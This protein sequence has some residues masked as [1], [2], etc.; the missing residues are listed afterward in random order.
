MSVNID[1]HYQCTFAENAGLLWYGVFRGTRSFVIGGLLWYEVFCDRGRFV[2]GGVLWYGVFCD[3]GFIQFGIRARRN[4]WRNLDKATLSHFP[5][6]IKKEQSL[7][8]YFWGTGFGIWIVRSARSWWIDYRSQLLQA[9]SNV[10]RRGIR[11]WRKVF[12]SR[13]TKVRFTYSKAVS[14]TECSVMRPT[15]KKFSIKNIFFTDE[16]FWIANTKNEER[17]FSL[18]KLNSEKK[19]KNTPVSKLIN[20]SINQWFDSA[21]QN[22]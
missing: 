12:A 10:L 20:Q 9:K 2:I 3:T 13:W 4:S 19:L 16:D 7:L 6:T 17:N 14:M 21:N 22:D 8:S 5:W 1:W 18:K 15:A 11:V